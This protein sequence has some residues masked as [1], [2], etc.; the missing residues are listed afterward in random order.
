MNNVKRTKLSVVVTIFE[1]LIFPLLV[2]ALFFSLPDTALH[3]S[4]PP[5]TVMS[6]LLTVIFVSRLTESYRRIVNNEITKAEDKEMASLL[7]IR[8]MALKGQII[9][10]DVVRES[11]EFSK[12]AEEC[13]IKLTG[14]KR[15][16][17][18]AAK[19]PD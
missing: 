5:L 19:K 6:I 2:T 12:E 18:V 16:L 1:S 11:F 14:Q 3:N 4:A 15:V 7:R 10:Q 9:N 8:D 17:A 13:S